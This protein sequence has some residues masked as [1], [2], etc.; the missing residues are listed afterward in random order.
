[1]EVFFIMTQNKIGENPWQKFHGPNLGYINTLF[2]EYRKDPNSVD[3][4]LKELFDQWGAPPISSMTV[5]E[6]KKKTED[7]QTNP[8]DVKKVVAIEKLAQNI[9]TYGHLAA[10]TD[11]FQ[12]IIDSNSRLLDPAEYGLSEED[13]RSLPAQV[14]WPDLSDSSSA[15]EAINRLNQIYTNSL[16]Y[17]FSHIQDM[18]ERNWLNHMVESDKA[19]L[20]ISSGEKIDLLQGLT[21]VES[22]EKFLHRT[23][24]GQKRFSVEGTDMMVPMI[25]EMIRAGVGDGIRNMMIG[26]AHRGRLNVLAHVLEKPYETIFSEFH[27]SPNKELVPSEGSMGIN[28]GWTGDVKYHLGANR[29]LA[30]GDTIVAKVSL[31]NNPSHLEF[32]NPVV[33]GYTRAAQEDRTS[34]G[35]A[36]Q[37]MKK[38]MAILVHGDA[39]FPGE[40]V[41]PETLNLSRLRGYQTGG[42]IHL[43]VN[44]RIGFTTESTDARSTKYASDLAKGFE[45]PIVHVNADDPEACLAAVRLAYHYRSRFHKDFLIDLIGYRRFG[46]NEMDD[47]AATQFQLYDRIE[48]HPTVR[49]L[50]AQNLESEG[51]ITSEHI[52]EMEQQILDRLQSAYKGLKEK[53]SEA[54]EVKDKSIQDKP[55]GDQLQRVK[56]AVPIESLRSIN[57]NLLEWPE[58]FTVYPKL[59]RILMR[60]KDALRDDGSVD[61]GL[62]ETLAFATILMDGTAVRLT[63]QD[64]ER[65]T[66]AHRHLMLHDPK[67]GKSF[68]PL[69]TLPGESASFSMYN[70]PLSEIAVLGFEYGYDVVAPDSLVLWEAQYGDFANAGQVIIDQFLAAGKAKWRQKSSLVLLLPHGYEG[71]GPEHS[72]ARLERFLQL[73]AENNWFVVNLT[74]SAQYFHLLRRQAAMIQS[75][76]TRPL[77]VMTPKGLIRN[78]RAVSSGSAFSEEQFHNILE[79]PGLGEKVDQVERLILCSGKIAIDLEAKVDSDEHQEKDFLHIVRVEQLYPFPENEIVQVIDRYA[80]LKEIVWVQEEPKN[81]G[82]WSYMEPRIR[83]I[84]PDQVSIKYIGRP[85]RSSPAEGLPN[86]HTNEQERILSEALAPGKY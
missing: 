53:E 86:I 58:G 51:V 7:P 19:Q 80:H 60:R 85:V 48:K 65:G 82:A 35:F 69:H 21:E 5:I 59:E 77:V 39:A 47:P 44:N 33:Q 10:K 38:A 42:T 3:E 24:V 12:E 29:E 78:K 37:D 26:M 1:L 62:A 20:S 22:F 64:T 45:I 4:D 27:H 61:W 66:F 14:I 46:H 71:Q 76:E 79:Q 63:G 83:A 67:S 15:F 11:P 2:E 73:S 43:I 74:K 72:S 57:N 17:Q 49:A 9:R 31:A 41:V 75:E 55:L 34:P 36:K 32:V 18:D 50:Y 16:S 70:S 25:N 56:T 52:Q 28:F 54:E 68:S 40:G 84:L 81:M 30:E 6:K 23:F 13:L 8:I